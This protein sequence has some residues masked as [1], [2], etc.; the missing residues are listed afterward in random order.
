MTPLRFYQGLVD[1]TSFCN[2]G[3]KTL[4]RRL[5][6]YNPPDRVYER[7]LFSIDRATYYCS[8][9]PM[10]DVEPLG[11]IAEWDEDPGDEAREFWDSLLCEWGSEPSAFE[12]RRVV[13]EGRGDPADYKIRPDGPIQGAV[14]QG[15]YEE[16]EEEDAREYAQGNFLV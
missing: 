12:W 10:L 8:A 1:V 15:E 14:L 2:F 7:V 11:Y 13:D 6:G 9:T 5:S 16:G 4:L 3:E